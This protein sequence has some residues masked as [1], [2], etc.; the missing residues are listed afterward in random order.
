[1]LLPASA[2]AALALFTAANAA[3]P[4]VTVRNGTYSGLYS[5][6]WDQDFFLGLP[7][8]QPPVGDLR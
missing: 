5:Q 1:M 3:P 8:A 7:F 6:E 4:T 2:L